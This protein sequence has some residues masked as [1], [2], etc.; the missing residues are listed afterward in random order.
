[1]KRVEDL[2]S[3]RW[4]A[5]D[6]FRSFGH[7]SRVLQM[8]YGPEDFI[9]KPVI[10][11]VN[12]WSDANQCHTHFKQRVEDVKRGILQAGGWPLELPA[13]SL[14]ESMVKPT[15]MLYRN[16]LAMETEELLR[17][18]P[19]DG[20]VLMGGCDKT[21][22]GLL[23]GAL[24]MGLPCIYLPAG[25]M[26]RGN[27]RGQVLGSG[28]DAFKY[29]DER[30]AGRLSDQAWAEMEA[31]I[32]RSHGT[33]MTMGTA[34]TMMGIAEAIGFTLPGASSIPAPDANHTRMSAEC[35][36]RIVQMVWDDRTPAKML[37]AG[38]F[39]NGI[40]VAMAMGCSTNAI[41]HLVAISRRAGLPV[42]LDDFDAASRHVGVIANIRPSG[43][44][45]LMEDFFYAGGLP[46]LMKVMAA[47]LDLSALTV[48][49]RSVGE[50]IAGAEVF[51]A[52]VIRPLD[53]PIYAEGALAVLRGNLAPDGVVIKPSAVAPHLLQHTG[54]ALVFDDYP[55]LKAAVDDPDL[56]VTGDDILV[57]RNAGPKGAGMP[58]W[59]MLPIPTK[60]LKAGVTD[61]LRLSDARMSGTSY[62]G[63]LLHCSPEAY[64]G[65]PL[66]L[67]KTGDRITVDVP[68]RSIRL[69]VSDEE[70]AARSK[71]WTPPPA[72]YERGYGWMFGRH[73]LQAHE[74][75]DFDFLETQFGAPVPEPVIY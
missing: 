27:W 75:C 6:D 66:A 47:K 17:S 7:R 9:N 69:E 64:V 67:V 20:A 4:F 56:D 42:T 55:S 61:M 57:L 30:R 12:T 44:A 28:S 22:P 5:K 60:L 46:A 45:Y 33:C 72:R 32:A 36:R 62:G 29:W 16:F 73:I 53:N 74:G 38:S 24:S 52:D 70:L 71:A 48:N 8:G 54:R 15:S 13:I 58:E 31:G 25:P 59:G 34:A 41:I 26:L 23:M 43:D 19:V 39:A 65:G 37:S 35:G 51:N 50:N 63:C 2:R 10:A 14:S 21:T 11:I 1:M 3:A 40:A 68:A 18:H 49:G